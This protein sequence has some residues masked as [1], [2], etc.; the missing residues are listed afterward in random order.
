MNE[1]GVD[2]EITGLLEALGSEPDERSKT[3]QRLLEL[4]YEELRA[5]AH[6]Q[7]AKL[8]GQQPRYMQTTELVHELYGRLEGHL[9]RGGDMPSSSEHFFALAARAMRQLI[10]DA[11]RHE[12]REKRGGA[13]QP[14]TLDEELLPDGQ[15]WLEPERIEKLVAMHRALEEIEKVN[16]EHVRLIEMHVFLGLTLDEVAQVRKRSLSTVKREWRRA[17]AWLSTTL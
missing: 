7:R 6:H 8:P 13:Q 4:V 14:I 17:R 5:L 12:S 10:I 15:L 3:W 2:S 16:P 9:E 1:D 11:V